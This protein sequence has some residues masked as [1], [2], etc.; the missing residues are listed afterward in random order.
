MAGRGRQCTATNGSEDIAAGCQRV[1][2]KPFWIHFK[3]MILLGF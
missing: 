2:V 1:P 3:V